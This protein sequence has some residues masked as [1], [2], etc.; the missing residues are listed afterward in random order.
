MTHKYELLQK[1]SKD[2]SRGYYLLL[3]QVRQPQADLQ[4]ANG[5]SQ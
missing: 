4:A 5:A 2:G 1:C 3:P